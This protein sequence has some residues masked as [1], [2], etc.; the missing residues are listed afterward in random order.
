MAFRAPQGFPEAASVE[1]ERIHPGRRE[2]VRLAHLDLAVLERLRKLHRHGRLALRDDEISIPEDLED[3]A[4][5]IG[6]P[7]DREHRDPVES[8][9]LDRDDAGVVEQPPERLR[10][11]RRR[12]RFRFELMQAHPA[13]RLAVEFGL[14]A[15]GQV[16]SEDDLVLALIDFVDVPSDQPLPFRDERPHIE[17]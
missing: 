9:L 13:A 6:T 1:F 17:G 5:G 14:P 2:C 3:D 10:E 4:E 8:P 7:F 11:R 12:L 16:D 15:A